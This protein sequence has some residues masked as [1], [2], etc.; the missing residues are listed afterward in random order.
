MKV[1]Y[2]LAISLCV[3]VLLFSSLNSFAL[4]PE[5]HLPEQQEQRARELFL[6]I[7]CPVCA[8][9]VIESSDTQIAFQ[10]RKLVREKIA[11][12]KSD[13]EIKSYLA[14]EYGD[15]IL[16]SPNFNFSNICLWV[17]PL[18]FVVCGVLFLRRIT[19]N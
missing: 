8:G 15:D 18:I 1:F 9:Q 7:K 13:E 17:L 10:L 16:N 11:D 12:G 5:Q 2:N 3:G 4:S 19:Q 14:T 6:Q